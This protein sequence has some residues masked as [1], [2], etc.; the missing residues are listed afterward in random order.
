[1]RA[2][3]AKGR[4]CRASYTASPRCQVD[5][6][7]WAA[8]PSARRLLSSSTTSYLAVFKRPARVERAA[9]NRVT[10][11]CPSEDPVTPAEREATTSSN[12]AQIPPGWSGPPGRILKPIP[13]P[14]ADPSF[15]HR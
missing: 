13:N 11:G 2:L 3:G 9:D 5:L 7:R 10:I 6:T 14:V 15:R 1:M 8:G 4:S 12:D